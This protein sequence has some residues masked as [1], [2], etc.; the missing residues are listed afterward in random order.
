MISSTLSAISKLAT[1]HRYVPVPDLEAKDNGEIN[2]MVVNKDP[3]RLHL[4][5]SLFRCLFC[6]LVGFGLSTTF[7]LF[8]RR[9]FPIQD[10]PSISDHIMKTPVPSSKILPSISVQK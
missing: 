6:F 3:N 8:W 7:G 10:V 5:Q 2:S 1:S 4:S 9:Q